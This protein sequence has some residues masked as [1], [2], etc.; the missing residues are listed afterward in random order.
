MN[1][2]NKKHSLPAMAASY[3]LGVF[4]D[5]YFKQAAMLLAVAAGLNQLQGWA[6]I[7]F[8][9]PFILFSAHGGWCADRFAKKKVVVFSKGLEVVAM[10]IGAYGLLAGSWPCILAMVFG[11][12]L[13]STFFSPSL[14]GSIPEQYP[15]ESV[16]RINAI[17]K[18]TTT[19]AILAG[20]ATAG[21]SLDQNWFKSGD[22]PFGVL[23]VA[24]TVILVAIGG[25]LAS[26]G[27]GS[28]PSRR[29]DQTKPFP[30]LGPINSI[31]D[32]RDICKDKHLFLAIIADTFFY[33]IASI[34]VLVI[35]AIGIQQF[36]FSQSM[37]SLLSVC[38]MLGVCVGS[39]LA[40]KLVRNEYWSRYL[41]RSAFGI[42]TGLFLAGMTSTLPEA[43]RFW[44]L[45]ASLAMA[46]IS[47]GLFLI[48]VTSLLQI[49]PDKSEKGRVLAAAG[50]S[51]FSAILLSGSIYNLLEPHM[52]PSTFMTLLALFTLVTSCVFFVIIPRDTTSKTSF[53]GKALRMML[54]L[55]YSI[56]VQGLDEL[57]LNENKGILFLPNHPALI[58]PV[59][60]MSTLHDRFSPRP[61]SAAEQ[62]NKPF[63]R[64]IMRMVNPILIPEAAKRGR[65]TKA[66]VHKAMDQVVNALKKGENMLFYPSG[67]L[68]RSAREDLAGNSG[69]EFILQNVPDVQVVLVRTTG[70]WGSSFSCASGKAPTLTRQLIHYM[71]A[72]MCNGLFF[73]PKRIV[74]V[75]IKADNS[76][77][78]LNE[79]TRINR[80]LEDYYNEKPVVR[81]HTPYYWWQGST[82]QPLPEAQ[83]PKNTNASISL[84]A[85]LKNQVVGRIEKLTGQQ[86]EA[87]QRLA[88]DLGLDSLTIME[89]ASWLE[90]EFGHPIEDPAVLD[91]VNDCILAAGGQLLNPHGV[92]ILPPTEKWFN[93]TGKTLTFHDANTITDVFLHQVKKTP[94][95]IVLADR[96]S[97][98]KSYRQLTTAIFALMPT[99]NTIQGDRVGIML[100]A[101]VSSA[102]VYLAAL[103][104]GKTPVMFNWTVGITNMEHGIK[105]TGVDA[106]ITA[107]PLCTKIEEQQDISLK[108]LSVDWIYLDEVVANIGKF[109]KISALL[110]SFYRI[111]K[112]QSATVPETA[113]ILFT[114][115]SESKPKAVPLSHSNILTNL[116]DFSTMLNFN[117]DTRLL[118]MLPPFHSLGLVGTMIMPLC[119][120]LRTVY[121]AN[122]TEPGIMAGIID[123]YKVTMVVATP[124]FLN[125][126]LQAGESEQLQSLRLAFT[127][128][129]KCPEY[130]LENLAQT[131]P[132]AEL[133][134]GYGITECSPLVSI[135][136]PGEARPGTIGRILPSIEHAIV[137]NDL[138]VRVEPGEQGLLLVKGKSIF[139][140]YLNSNAG[141]GFCEFEGELWYQTGDYVRLDSDGHLIFCGRKK[142][143]IK[144]AGEMIS[145]PAIES[146]LLKEIHQQSESGPILAVEATQTESHPEIVLFTTE[147]LDRKKINKVLKNAGLS[148]LHNIRRL[149]QIDSIPVLGTGKTDYK[150]LQQMLVL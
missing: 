35:N 12:G 134:E 24:A 77:K 22:I 139:S 114:S 71:K 43:I 47:G 149:V 31:L 76:I 101:S 119:L 78:S 128:A 48:P 118:G 126:I 142:R 34:T 10:A 61:L 70:L 65:D 14:N 102:I 88:N 91:T 19:L 146:T 68:N 33:F 103:F 98:T 42:T 32:L 115:G 37:T 36:G 104:S 87:D 105:E 41:T 75:Q 8:A 28:E 53:L 137:S 120:G 130:V 73:G 131:V 95:K 90:S 30:W 83:L 50:F 39:F 106:I 20:I 55:R 82:P 100:P 135:N 29:A 96:I 7:L 52:M 49:R 27:M 141:K 1:T 4:N 15:A 140:G 122:P 85:S 116:R 46:G 13:Q 60:V 79:R 3:C 109:K 69:V 62:V 58:D 133:C 56:E 44:W 84:P 80:Y 99:M 127:G 97:G 64:Q 136:L 81:T 144:I 121:H 11:M 25:F 38:L 108:Q 94:G 18:L 93:S 138:A 113:A 125:G 72:L 129:E 117:D 111:R 59:I 148:A 150:V 74:K 51:S 110:Q 107:G 143:F 63:V 9:L 23:L 2:Q 89:L 66:S 54:S 16:P 57:Q 86:P 112:L 17:L 147:N 6:A 45:G 132:D 124:T 21:I 26:L 67:R 40:A 123:K 145:L 92:D 5:N